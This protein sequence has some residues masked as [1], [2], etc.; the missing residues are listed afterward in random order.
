MNT[1]RAWESYGHDNPYFGVLADERFRGK[2]LSDTALNEFFASGNAD[3]GRVLMNIDRHLTA[4]PRI[5]ALDFGCGVG[6]L[7]IPLAQHFTTVVGVDI[8]PS[9]LRE[10][11][12][13]AHRL[14]VGNLRL[15][16]RLSELDAE[17]ETFS[18]VNT[19]IVLQHI[20]AERGLA[21]IEQLLELLSKGGCGAIHLTYARE[22]YRQTLGAKPLSSRV[23]EALRRPI[24]GL[25][26]KFS[27]RDPEMQMNSYQMNKVLF[28]LQ[29]NGI[30]EYFSEFTNH[31]GYMGITLYFRK[32]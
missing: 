7:A 6:R 18:F 23:I 19:L 8:S 3:V 26:R 15:C 2:T 16:E 29:S 21:F 4:P 30:T 17:R 12:V 1:D 25:H 32:P 27:G 28:L 20:P 11:T 31:S 5:K 10:T 24:S 14:N 13:N 9:M 22:K